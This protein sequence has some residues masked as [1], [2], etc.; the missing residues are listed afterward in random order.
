MS[1]HTL[2]LARHGQSEGNKLNVYSGWRDFALTE[3]GIAEARAAGRLL[4]AQGVRVDAAFTSGLQRAASTCQLMLAE[5]GQ[6]DLPVTANMALN[7]RDYGALVGLNKAESVTQFGAEQ[8]QAWR[9]SFAVAPPE[10]ESLRDTVA[11]VLP[12]YV[13]IILPVVMRH[14]TTLVV[15]HG[16]SLRALIMALEGHTPESIT[17]V[18]LATGEIR[19]FELDASTTIVASAVLQVA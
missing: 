10:G 6:S 1:A 15:A 3:Q 5:L 4:H 9:R 7:E 13:H 8:V 14:K 16:N 11:R 18:E 12:Y 2:L 17:K 19:S